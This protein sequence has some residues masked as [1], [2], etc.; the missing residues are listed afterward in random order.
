MGFSSTSYYYIRPLVSLH[1]DSFIH[2]RVLS[3]HRITKNQL[4]RHKKIDP[5]AIQPGTVACFLTTVSDEF[6]RLLDYY[7]AWEEFK[8]TFRNYISV[9]SSTAK[10]SKKTPWPLKAVPICSPET[11]VSNYLTQRNNPE[12]GRIRFYRG[13]SLRFHKNK[14]LFVQKIDV[15]FAGHIAFIWA[16]YPG[17]KRPESEGGLTSNGRM[18]RSPRPLLTRF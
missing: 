18:R 2:F 8:P 13:R 5:R 16:L 14:W 9:T 4:S 10:M 12:D 11:S 17:A 6:F 15:S 3:G 1:F 7:L